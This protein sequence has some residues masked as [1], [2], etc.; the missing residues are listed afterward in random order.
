MKFIFLLMAPLFL[1]I[2]ANANNGSGYNGPD[3]SP[4]SVPVNLERGISLQ[5]IKDSLNTCTVAGRAGEMKSLLQNFAL[6]LGNLNIYGKPSG[7]IAVKQNNVYLYAYG[8]FRAS[9]SDTNWDL[10]LETN[11]RETRIMTNDENGK[12]TEF[13][14]EEGVLFPT[15]HFD[16]ILDEGR[17]DD[18]GNLVLSTRIVS[19]LRINYKISEGQSLSKLKL[20]NYDTSQPALF[21]INAEEYIQCLNLELQLNSEK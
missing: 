16:K 19:Q 18:F 13:K 4:L 20:L 9:N 6:Q 11:D 1:A 12:F 21:T 3:L 14:L 17:Y 7:S 2:N 5:A 8:N 10:S 15:L